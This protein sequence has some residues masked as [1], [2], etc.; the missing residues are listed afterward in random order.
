MSVGSNRI[1]K[2]RLNG[3]FSF[4]SNLIQQFQGIPLKNHSSPHGRDC[5]W[6]KGASR[7]ARKSK[8]EERKRKTDEANRQVISSLQLGTLICKMLATLDKTVKWS[9][10]HNSWLKGSNFVWEPYWELVIPSLNWPSSH[11]VEQ[12]HNF[13]TYSIYWSMGRHMGNMF[14]GQ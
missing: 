13:P 7:W 1:F 5:G 8:G 9:S 11:A 6:E 12:W 10:V 3:E 4:L 2:W 14:V